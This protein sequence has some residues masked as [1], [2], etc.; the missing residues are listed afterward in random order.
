MPKAFARA[1]GFLLMFG[2]QDAGEKESAPIRDRAADVGANIEISSNAKENSS[3]TRPESVEEK[4]IEPASEV[5]NSQNPS[6][7]KAVISEN[8]QKIKQDSR[9]PVK[10]P[11]NLTIVPQDIDNM[12]AAPGEG[13]SRDKIIFFPSQK[14]VFSLKGYDPDCSGLES[15]FNT[16]HE[17]IG[18]G[19]ESHCLGSM[20]LSGEKSA[21][22]IKVSGTFN[23]VINE[24]TGQIAP[25][26]EDIKECAGAGISIQYTPQ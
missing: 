23:T 2:A 18:S 4:E 1:L 11:L 15:L 14:E 20:R 16:V 24:E 13:N 10:V 25:A 6:H 8:Y 19:V 26:C 9:S 12:N 22:N 3:V 5:K 7:P 21:W 17:N